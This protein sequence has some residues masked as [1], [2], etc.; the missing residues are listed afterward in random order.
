[1]QRIIHFDIMAEKP[2]RAV[3]FYKNVFGWKIDKWKGPVDYWLAITGKENEPGIN[4]GI[5][6]REKHDKGIMTYM[7][8]IE[9]NSIKT[10]SKKII[11][12]GGKQITQ[13]MAIPGVGWF[14]R[15]KD[16]EGNTF[17]L[18]QTDTSTR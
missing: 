11:K 5:G 18:M 12:E 4:G 15:F 10:Y 14:A 9:V 6:K 7:C 16:S 1:M 17:G 2:E 13:K 8:T 3:K